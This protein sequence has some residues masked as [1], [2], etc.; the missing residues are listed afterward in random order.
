MSHTPPFIA[1]A[2]AT[3]YT[4]HMQGTTCGCDQSQII[5]EWVWTTVQN[6][7]FKTININHTSI[8]TTTMTYTTQQ[9]SNT[10]SHTCT[11]CYLHRMATGT[12][13][14]HTSWA[15]K[16]LRTH[17]TCTEMN[18]TTLGEQM[19]TQTGARMAWRDTGTMEY[20]INN[21]KLTKHHLQCG[22]QPSEVASPNQRHHRQYQQVP[23]AL[24]QQLCPLP[25]QTS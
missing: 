3:L 25:Q 1:T 14:P 23:N 2:T 5:K 15:E 19:H 10:H 8:I 11:L 4:F 9:R 12:C 18:G 13:I 16:K 7:K 6:S 20:G 21:K 17:Q 22:P 24:A